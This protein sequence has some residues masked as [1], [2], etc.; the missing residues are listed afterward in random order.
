MYMSH[1][2]NYSPQCSFSL[3][4]SLHPKV[5]CAVLNA[6]TWRSGKRFAEREWPS[7]L[8][9]FCNENLGKSQFLVGKLTI[10]GNF[11]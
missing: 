9:T 6:R 3:F 1:V 11:P 5:G 10:N 2:Y 4:P 8:G 7:L